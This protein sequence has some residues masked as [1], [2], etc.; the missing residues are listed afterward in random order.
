M[1]LREAAAANQMPER[2]FIDL[3]KRRG[4]IYKPPRAREW[5]AYAEPR[6]AGL[7]EHKLTEGDGQNGERWVS[8]RV[9]VTTRG[10]AHIAKLIRSEQGPAAQP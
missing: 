3:L 4:L 9:R 10:L 6:S 8:T 2:K 5:W 7:L 1:S